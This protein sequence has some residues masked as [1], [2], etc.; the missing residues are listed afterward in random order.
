VTAGTTLGMLAADG[1]AVFGGSYVGRL[2]SPAMLHRIAAA[3]F[4]VLGLATLAAALA[5]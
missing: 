1:A 3:L 5:P 4:L 2:V